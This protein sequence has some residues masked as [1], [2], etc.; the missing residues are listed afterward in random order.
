MVGVCQF[1]RTVQKPVHSSTLR[2]HA[3]DRCAS[4]TLPAPDAPLFMLAEYLF[5]MNTWPTALL[6]P[7]ALCKGKEHLAKGTN[8]SLPSLSQESLPDWPHIFSRVLG[9]C[10]S[11]GMGF[12]GALW[13]GNL[14]VHRAG[15]FTSMPRTHRALALKC[16][17]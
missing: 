15:H 2:A 5:S 8:Q 4:H 9:K 7:A 16:G 3:G 13:E 11:T 17:S 6:S 10:N 1:W 12:T 14:P